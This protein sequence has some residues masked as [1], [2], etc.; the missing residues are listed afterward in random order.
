MP[1]TDFT[2]AELMAIAGPPQGRSA[3]PSAPRRQ[4]APQIRFADD[5]DALIRTVLGE[6]GAEP[7][8]GQTAVA[9]VVLNRAR[10]RGL[11]PSEVVLER[12][13]F[14]PWGNPNTAS[15]LMSVSPDDPA[16]Q[17]A[18]RQVDMA[19]QGQDPTNGADH[20][21]A[22][23][24]QAA[25]GRDAPGWASGDPMVIGGH[26]F[27]SLG[28]S[29]EDARQAAAAPEPDFSDDELMQIASGATPQAPGGAAGTSRE[30]PIDLSSLTDETVQ[31]LRQGAWVTNPKTGETYALPGDAWFGAPD[32]SSERVGSNAYLD[33]PDMGDT[34][35]AAATAFSE[36]IPFGDELVAAGAGAISGRGYDAIREQQ[37]TERELL[38]QTNRSARNVGGVAGFGAGFALPGGKWVEG[39]TGAAR[40][41]RAAALS[42]GYSALYGAGNTDGDLKER[43]T[44][45]VIQGGLGA[46]GG[47]VFQ[48]GS[49]ALGAVA[50]NARA[51]PSP[52]RQLSAAGVDLTPGQMIGGAAQRMEDGVTSVPILGDAIRDARRRGLETFNQAA[53]NRAIQPVGGTASRG[54]QGIQEADAAVS[55]AYDSALQGVQV[56]RDSAFDAQIT[57][58]ARSNP[59]PGELQP[60][61][62]A[63]LNNTLQRVGQ[64]MDGR[65]WKQL[66]SELSASVRAAQS[67]SQTN[68]VQRLMADKLGQMR[69][70]VR[71]MLDRA[72]PTAAAAVAQADE[73]AAGMYRIRD[74][75]QSLGTSARDGIFTPGDLNRA[76]RNGDSSAGNRQFA[77]GEAMLQDLSDAAT[78]VLPSTV[79]DSG[80]PFRS[81]LAVGGVGGGATTMTGGAALP[82]V[83]ATGAGL[84]GGAGAYSRPIQGILNRAYRASTPGAARQALA[85]FQAVAAKTPALQPVYEALQSALRPL[86]LGG[87]TATPTTR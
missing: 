86:L 87:R 82:V 48:R 81:M 8:E 76:V 28:G 68:P 45:A 74:A 22:P 27:Y 18:A 60:Q 14:E 69:E 11:S 23:R 42:G 17:A 36:Q 24:A 29:T 54:R 2:T 62:G 79:P 6:A 51:N 33:R 72:D 4:A 3:Q 73:A 77:R 63:L 52:A 12:N 32:S 34:A 49:D 55:Q 40:L 66:D 25:L 46:G 71:G 26:N 50:R 9:A 30:N 5:R 80:T 64:G 38:N 13:Q 75:G 78:Q 65:A 1:D 15:R 10:Q 56:P 59:L 58:I 84:F 43:L 57:Q 47:A 61:F 39:G 70:A 85:D 19:L 41:G 83:A 44:A 7:P 37:A 67:G 21:Y 35:L 20:F 16:Y 53:I 31:A